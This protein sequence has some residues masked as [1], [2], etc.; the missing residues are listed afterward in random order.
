LFTQVVSLQEAETIIHRLRL[1]AAAQRISAPAL[2]ADIEAAIMRYEN[3]TDAHDPTLRRR[4]VD[5]AA[6]VEDHT[7]LGKDLQ[8]AVYLM[9]LSDYSGA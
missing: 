8:L 3:P 6:N 7:P 9:M 1:V 4:L 2:A 5:R